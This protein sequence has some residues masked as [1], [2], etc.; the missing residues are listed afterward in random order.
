MD[1]VCAIPRPGDSV[2][3]ISLADAL[4][5]AK[6]TEKEKNK[7]QIAEKSREYREKNKKRMVA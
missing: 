1:N 2:T 4:Q 3:K 7:E 6:E 5:I